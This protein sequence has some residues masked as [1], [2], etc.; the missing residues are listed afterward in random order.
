[1]P[2]M[3]VRMRTFLF[4]T[5]VGTLLAFGLPILLTPV[6]WARLF[7]WELPDDLRLVRYFARSLGSTAVAIGVTGVYLSF[8]QNP[9]REFLLVAILSTALLTVIH[10]VGTIERS[11]PWTET[12]EIA[13]W[14]AVT[15]WGIA[16]YR[17]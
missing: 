9:P 5:G 8:Q 4:V 6:R 11:Q 1:M 3:L 16:V 14:F 15:V 12:V 10:L 2:D 13:F 7:R 17:A